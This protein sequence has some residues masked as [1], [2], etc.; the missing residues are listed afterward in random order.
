M[1]CP[2]CKRT[3]LVEITLTVAE[4]P[5]VM[6]SC[7]SCDRRWWHREGETLHLPGVLDLAARR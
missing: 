2:D 6:R 4:Q 1:R 3:Y 7:S 5:L